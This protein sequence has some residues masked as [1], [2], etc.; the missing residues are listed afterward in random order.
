MK[1][2]KQLEN[3]LP[4]TG[5]N[6]CIACGAEIPEGFLVCFACENGTNDARCEGCGRPIP[7]GETV[8]EE[9]AALFAKKRK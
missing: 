8:C 7:A 2:E 4:E 5:V 1:S 9:C 6:T 3:N